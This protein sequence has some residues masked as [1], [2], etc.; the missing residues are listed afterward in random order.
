MAAPILITGAAGFVGSHLLDLLTARETAVVGWY[1]PN[2]PPIDPLQTVTWLAIELLDRD[3]VAHAIADLRPSAIYH[4]AGAAHVAQS[5][6]DTVETYEGNVLATHHLFEGLRLADLHPRVFV[7]GSAMIY[8]PQDRPIREEDP[9]GPASP[10][11]TSKLAQELLAQRAW[12]TDGLP[13]L[14][15]RAFNHVGPRQDPSFVAAGIARQ[16]ALIEAGR[17]P[18]VLSMGNLEPKRDLTDV[19]DTVRAYVAM[20]D[21]ATPGRP[22]NV[23]SGRGLSIG[24]LVQTF[25]ARA[26]TRVDVVQD[27][28]RFRPN[29][30]PLL[31]GDHER[32]SA[33]TGWQPQVPFEQTVDD[34]LDYW[35]GRIREM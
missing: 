29:D 33:D 32:L 35:R 7:A 31:V 24:A 2:A 6:R 27:P 19:R 30:V 26:R 16:I 34:L 22:Y 25:T 14:L 8:Q 3:A 5:W 9:L 17:Q 1:R 15:A 18:P 10:Y 20:M 23:C 11:A 12:E 13:T 21:S 28:S 4:L